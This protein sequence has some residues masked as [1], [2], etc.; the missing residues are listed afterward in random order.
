MARPIAVGVAVAVVLA[1]GGIGWALVSGAG[2][3]R[4]ADAGNAVDWL[5]PTIEAAGSPTPSPSPSRSATPKPSRSAKPSPSATRTTKKPAPR[6]TPSRKPPKKDLPPPPNPNPKPTATG[7]DCPSKTGTDASRAAVR[8]ALEA[9]GAR[10]YWRGVRLPPEL[11]GEL[12]EITVPANLMKAVAWQES[13]WQSTILACDGGIGTMQIMPATGEWMNSRFGT[14]Y[15]VNTL[16]GNT[17]LGAMYLEW[18]IMYFGLY[19]FGSFDLDATAEVGS[20]GETLRLLD[21]V[22][23]AYNV[24]PYALESDDGETLSIPNPRYV[25]NVTALMTECEC[26]SY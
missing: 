8:D 23:A 1:L 22:V 18:E 7:D 4:S 15:N 21:V 12:P 2:P 24:G 11:N 6:P 13:G 26:L 19:Y 25:Q 3:A 14:D 16:A 9:A 17:S 10:Q 20:D 5:D